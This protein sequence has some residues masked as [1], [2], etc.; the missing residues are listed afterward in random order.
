MFKNYFI[1]IYLSGLLL[2]F[3]ACAGTGFVLARI[4]ATT[5]SDYEVA[6]ENPIEEVPAIIQISQTP[7]RRTN[8]PNWHEIF[9]N[10]ITNLEAEAAMMN[11]FTEDS[12]NYIISDY[13]YAPQ[14]PAGHIAI[15]FDDGPHP[16]LTPILLDALYERNVRATFFL[17]G[18]EVDR[19]P[20]IVARMYEEGH[21]IGNHSF[22]HPHFTRISRQRVIDEIYRTNN[23]IKAITGTTPTVLRPPY[24][25]RNSAV[26]NIARDMD[27]A[28]IMWSVDPRD[29]SLRDANLVS[30]HIINHTYDGSIVLLHDIHE[31]SIEAAIIAI[32]ELLEQGFIFVTVEELFE[33]NAMSL[34]AGGVYRSIYHTIGGPQ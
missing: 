10:I 33:I 24:G 5:V 21:L 11:N 12:N 22:G 3:A 27:M 16:T 17:L 2:A 19:H 23:S 32:D 28:V 1:I 4:D 7:S 31:S 14:I 25:A 26:L 20:H 13:D 30:E 34:N 18:M 8:F 29:W 6:P 9:V 15:T